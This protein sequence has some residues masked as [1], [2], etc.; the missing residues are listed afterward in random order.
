MSGG[1][2][3]ALEGID[4][5]GKTTHV[6]RLAQRLRQ[7]GHDVTRVEEPGGTEVGE[8]LRELILDA[9]G[10]V[11]PL[12]ELLMLEASRHE[13]VRQVI[14]P[15]LDRGEVV[16]SHRYDYSSIAYQGYGRGL[17]IELIRYLNAEATQDIRPNLVLWLDL[18]A[19]AAWERLQ[20]ARTPDRLEGEGL[21]FLERVADGY[22]ALAEE[23]PEMVRIDANQPIDELFQDLLEAIADETALPVASGEGGCDGISV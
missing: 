1:T 20:G 4:G 22:R 8:R 5:S 2:F 23:C 16:I 15:A 11:A 13:L 12:S 18:P 19:D 21:A 10:T 9:R 14:R 7:A 17:D 6:D 3:L